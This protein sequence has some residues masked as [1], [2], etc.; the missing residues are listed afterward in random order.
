MRA[1]CGRPPVQ[2]MEKRG[3]RHTLAV[4]DATCV[5]PRRLD[6]TSYAGR[7]S[8]EAWKA[9]SARS[10]SRASSVGVSAHTNKRPLAKRTRLITHAFETS[11]R[12][13][14]A[15][16][17]L[18]GTPRLAYADSSRCASADF[19]HSGPGSP[20]RSFF[21]PAICAK[22]INSGLFIRAEVAGGQPAKCGCREHKNR[23]SV[24]CPPFP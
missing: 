1:F 6:S 11:L 8:C 23:A 14:G 24:A 15:E 21:V 7:S 4:A 19:E 10:R 16:L 9:N 2:S 22:P 20:A 12:T 5:P 17:R 13:S 18:R 3:A